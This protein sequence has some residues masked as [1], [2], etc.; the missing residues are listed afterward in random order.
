MYLGAMNQT[1]PSHLKEVIVEMREAGAP[2]I[3]AYYTGEMYIALE[4][5]HRLAAAWELGLEPTIIE[6]DEDDEMDHDLEDL[7]STRAT[8]AEIM[9][10]LDGQAWGARYEIDAFN[11][12]NR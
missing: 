4:G 8:V 6:M 7:N 2:E 12:E 11:F 9:D 3:R 10:C 5:S 1:E